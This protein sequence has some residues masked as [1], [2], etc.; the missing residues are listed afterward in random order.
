MRVLAGG[1]ASLA[2]AGTGIAS[3]DAMTIPTNV[4]YFM[5]VASRSHDRDIDTISRTKNCSVRAKR[6]VTIGF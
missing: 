4:M 6:A 1:A 3:A 5:S 2:E